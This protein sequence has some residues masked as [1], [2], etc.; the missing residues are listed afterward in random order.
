VAVAL[1][2]GQ[3]VAIELLARAR[4]NESTGREIGRFRREIFLAAIGLV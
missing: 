4:E 1:S 2:T 3:S